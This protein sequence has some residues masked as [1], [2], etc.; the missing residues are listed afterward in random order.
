MGNQN[1]GH[2]EGRKSEPE[3]SPKANL[4]SSEVWEGQLCNYCLSSECVCVYVKSM[5]CVFNS[6][7]RTFIQL[8]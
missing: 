4:G 5:I 6:Q 2:K 8:K 1:E 3:E 7:V